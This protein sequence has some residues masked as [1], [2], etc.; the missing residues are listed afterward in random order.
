MTTL[1]G[2]AT[3]NIWA[4]DHA[5]AVKWYGELLNEKPYFERPGYAEFRVGD[6]ETELGIIDSSYAPYLTFP[7]KPA[8]V[9]VYWQVDDV[10]TLFAE[11][12]TMDAMELEVPKD[13]GNGFITATV[14]DPFGNIFGIMQNP[15]Y[16][17]MFKV[18]S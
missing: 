13:R 6:Y 15:H 12:L 4:A 3:I 8:G 17:E 7:D 10:K 11:L 18:V 2:I 16:L 1:R 14:V 9:V 5:K